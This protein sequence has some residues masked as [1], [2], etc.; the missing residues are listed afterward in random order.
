M[1]TKYSNDTVGYRTHDL[2]AY[3]AVFQPT[4]PSHVPLGKHVSA[5]TNGKQILI[6]NSSANC[7]PPL[8][9]WPIDICFFFSFVIPNTAQISA[10]RLYVVVQGFLQ[11]EILVASAGSNATVLKSRILHVAARE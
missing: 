1:S 8:Y 11:D 7:V 5:K 3:S 2:P 10:R 9:Y 4:A 6:E